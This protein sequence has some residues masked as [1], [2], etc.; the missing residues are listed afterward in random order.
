ML[1]YKIYF[2]C[3]FV[4]NSI[5]VKNSECLVGKYNNF[6]WMVNQNPRSQNF[7]K[8]ISFFHFLFFLNY[9]DL[10]ACTNWHNLIFD[11]WKNNVLR[12][13][14]FFSAMKSKFEKVYGWL[15]IFKGMSIRNEEKKN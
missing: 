6:C 14:N 5:E 15:S 12:L 7:E 8:G 13:L 2:V 11:S 1:G 9:G 4:F 10:N 3:A